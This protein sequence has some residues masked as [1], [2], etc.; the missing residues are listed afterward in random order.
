MADYY[1]KKQKELSEAQ[2]QE[3]AAIAT[4]MARPDVQSV[5]TEQ[6]KPMNAIFHQYATQDKILEIGGD[7]V[8]SAPIEMNAK[9]FLKFALSH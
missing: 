7:L 2:A 4:F 3:K 5:L 9:E 6:S 1:S 8:T